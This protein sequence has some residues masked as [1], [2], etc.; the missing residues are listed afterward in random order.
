MM[1]Q[2]WCT[3]V[4]YTTPLKSARVPQW[5]YVQRV[6]LRVLLVPPLS[7]GSPWCAAPS[8]QWFNGAQLLLPWPWSG[9]HP[10]VVEGTAACVPVSV[11]RRQGCPPPAG[12]EKE[13]STLSSSCVQR[14]WTAWYILWEPEKQESSSEE[15]VFSLQTACG[16]LR[17]ESRYCFSPGK[18]FGIEVGRGEEAEHI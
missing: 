12:A 6:P 5:F 18:G 7:R 11:W 17:A 14:T 2:L 3:Y 15:M 13:L 9:G 4:S 16:C 10:E 1:P 8:P